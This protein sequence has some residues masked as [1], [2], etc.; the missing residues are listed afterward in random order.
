MPAAI[1]SHDS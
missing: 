1:A